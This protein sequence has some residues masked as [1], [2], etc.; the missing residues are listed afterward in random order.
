MDTRDVSWRGKVKVSPKSFVPV[1]GLK[2]L[3][4]SGYLSFEE[5]KSEIP[6]VRKRGNVGQ[7]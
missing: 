2:K 3:R 1:F 7:Q 5:V 6:L 4:L